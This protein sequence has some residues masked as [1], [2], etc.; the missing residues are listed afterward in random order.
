MQLKKWM[1]KNGRSAVWVGNQINE[2]AYTVSRLCLG[3]GIN[4]TRIFKVSELT[5]GEVN[6]NDWVKLEKARK[7]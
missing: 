4:A 1:E 3:I 5:N 6:I 2:T 7:K